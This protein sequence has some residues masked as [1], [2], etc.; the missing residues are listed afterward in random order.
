[1]I[2]GRHRGLP[3]AIDRAVML[4]SEFQR[5]LDQDDRSQYTFR[6][7]ST[8]QEED[9]PQDVHSEHRRQSLQHREGRGADLDDSILSS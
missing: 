4:P 1:M 9:I 5:S 7:S 8:I 3:V 2:R 6:R